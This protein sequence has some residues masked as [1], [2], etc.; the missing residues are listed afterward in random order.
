[1]K[2]VFVDIDGV[3]NTPMWTYRNDKFIC[4]Y[5]HPDDGKVNN[6]QAICW[7][8]ELCHKE[9]LKIVVSSVWRRLCDYKSVFYKSGL[10]EDIEILGS[11]PYLEGQTR[12]QEI[13]L[14]LQ[15]HPEIESF[16]ILDD[17]S[18][19]D[20][21]VDHLIRCSTGHGFGFDEFF[22]AR[23]LLKSLVVAKEGNSL[24]YT[25]GK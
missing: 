24:K 9:D 25:K 2:V 10:A 7:L 4:S 17:G 15:E 22:E 3:L 5:N 14:Y 6:F 21:L 18:D 19:M 13:K 23:N 12:G 16:I 11:T 1:M 8:N 20:D